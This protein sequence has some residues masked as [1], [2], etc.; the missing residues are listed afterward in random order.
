MKSLPVIFGMALLMGC[1]HEIAADTE[2]EPQAAFQ[3][4]V[5]SQRAVKIKC[6]QM[7]PYDREK[8]ILMLRKSKTI[9]PAMTEKEQQQALM[10]YLKEKRERFAKQCR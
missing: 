5:V 8:L 9:L 3:A 4:P 7:P 6:G 2:L 1:S 10:M